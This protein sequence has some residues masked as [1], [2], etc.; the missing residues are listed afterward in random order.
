MPAPILYASENTPARSTASPQIAQNPGQSPNP[1][2]PSHS[3]SVAQAEPPLVRTP[4]TIQELDAPADV[5]PPG[6]IRPPPR[7]PHLLPESVSPVPNPKIR[8]DREGKG[9]FGAGRKKIDPITGEVIRYKHKA[10]DIEAK[11]GSNISSPVDGKITKYGLPYTGEKYRYVEIE[12]DDGHRVRMFYV[13][14]LTREG[15]R[16]LKPGAQIKKGQVIGTQQDIAGRKPGWRGRMTNHAC[17][18]GYHP[19]PLY[20]VCL[21]GLQARAGAGALRRR[22]G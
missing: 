20:V 8:D 14:P 21:L 6:E 9:F 10:L 11:A 18:S 15:E 2:D 3:R 1:R 16:M 4:L 5:N 17:L 13:K 22:S 7:K 12:T 19:H